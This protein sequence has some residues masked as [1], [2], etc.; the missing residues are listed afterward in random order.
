MAN[1]G[2]QGYV[3]QKKATSEELEMTVNSDKC[4]INFAL[5]GPWELIDKK[6]KSKGIKELWVEYTKFVINGQDIL[7]FPKPA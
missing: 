4:K 6:D 2:S 5:R 7:L 1:F 3:I